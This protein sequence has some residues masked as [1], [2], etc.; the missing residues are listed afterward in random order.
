M[1]TLSGSVSNRALCLDYNNILKRMHG[2][3]PCNSDVN[4]LTN[5]NVGG[6]QELL[7]FVSFSLSVRIE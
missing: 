4:M 7:R 2:V 6:L 1:V 3:P 5:Y